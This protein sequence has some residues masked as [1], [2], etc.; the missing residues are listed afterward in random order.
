MSY[1]LDFRKKVFKV[2]KDQSLT[3][4]M[5]SERFAVPIRTL[6]RW[7]NR[8]EPKL[9]RD[10]TGILDLKALR[11]AIEIHPDKFQYE[12]AEKYGVSQPTICKWLKRLGVSYKKNTISP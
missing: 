6:F 10:R 12:L 4:Q 1:S 8:I 7:A 9:T 2:K 11:K 3:Y 5:T